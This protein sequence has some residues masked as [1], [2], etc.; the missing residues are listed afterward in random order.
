MAEAFRRV[1]PRRQVMIVQREREEGPMPGRHGER[2][3]KSLL[4]YFPASGPRV[5]EKE[6]KIRRSASSGAWRR[7]SERGTTYSDV[8][9]KRSAG[10][11]PVWRRED[12][13]K[14]LSPPSLKAVVTLYSDICRM[15]EEG[16]LLLWGGRRRPN[17]CHN[18][19]LRPTLT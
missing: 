1:V 8:G 7:R 3:G 11:S 18:S 16:L 9:F 12:L 19:A 13:R 4:R 15:A 17:G 5:S 14:A 2:E 6:Q 10:A